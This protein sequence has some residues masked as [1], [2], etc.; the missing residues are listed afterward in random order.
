MSIRVA[1]DKFI[2]LKISWGF[3]VLVL[4]GFAAGVI[5]LTTVSGKAEQVPQ[6]QETLNSMDKRLS[7]IEFLLERKR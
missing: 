5:W 3:A 6:I 1:E 7:R 4:G 2:P